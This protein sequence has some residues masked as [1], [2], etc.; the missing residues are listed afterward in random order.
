M[1]LP[2][3]IKIL[4]VLFKTIRMIEFVRKCGMRVGNGCVSAIDSNNLTDASAVVYAV[5]AR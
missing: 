2:L 4:Y 3:K 5:S 1:K